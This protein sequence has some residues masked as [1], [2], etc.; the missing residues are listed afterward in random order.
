MPETGNTPANEKTDR[1]RFREKRTTGKREADEAAA[2]QKGQHG[3]AEGSE[4]MPESAYEM[5]IAIANQGY[6]EP[7]MEA[8]R[9]AGAGGGTVIHAKAPEWK[10]WGNF[11]VCRLQRKKK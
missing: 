10:E 2:G 5:S 7:I 6:I 3:A 11:S 9:S 4:T 1:K 8:A